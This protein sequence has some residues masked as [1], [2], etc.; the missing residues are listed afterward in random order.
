MVTL[1]AAVITV[2]KQF[3]HLVPPSIFINTDHF[4]L[5][6][7]VLSKSLSASICLGWSTRR[8]R[9]A[10]SFATS[11]HRSDRSAILLVAT[12]SPYKI[13]RV[14]IRSKDNNVDDRLHTSFTMPSATSREFTTSQASINVD[15]TTAWLVAESDT[16]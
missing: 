5:T 7:L 14:I 11:S 16:S 15:T 1:V 9:I 10:P 2:I 13:C 3:P 12:G 6:G 8:R 4:L